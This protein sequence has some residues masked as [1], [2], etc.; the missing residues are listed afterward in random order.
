MA[1]SASAQG[2]VFV[3]WSDTAQAEQA[4]FEAEMLSAIEALPQVDY[5]EYINDVDTWTSFLEDA[6]NFEDYDGMIICES[7]SS[8]NSDGWAA[9]DY[10]LPT[11]LLEPYVMHKSSWSWYAFAD[12]MLEIHNLDGYTASADRFVEVIEEPEHP[13]FTGFN[14]SAGDEVIFAQSIADSVQGSYAN[15]LT[16]AIADVAD[17]ATPL[18]KNKDAVTNSADFQ[19]NMWAIEEN[20]TTPRIFLWGYHASDLATQ[21]DELDMLMQNA[22]LWILGE[23]ITTAVDET[24]APEASVKVVG[25]ELIISGVEVAQ[26]SVFNLT[27]ANV[28]TA[29]ATSTVSLA[30]LADG[31]YMVSVVDASGAVSTTKVIK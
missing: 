19:Y 7:G 17:N 30:G 28:L 15:D 25:E 26:V 9:I 14:F 16:A 10:P 1:M 13:I 4:G 8:S 11:L 3:A 29:N 21:N 5:I 24:T 6:A 20:A 31:I 12:G 18:A 27:G 23:E 22:A 2:Y